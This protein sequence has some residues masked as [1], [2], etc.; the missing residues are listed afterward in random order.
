MA[1]RS[2][3]GEV[4]HKRH[5]PL[6]R[7]PLPQS[8]GGIFSRGLRPHRSPRF[9]VP[10]KRMIFSPIGAVANPWK[11]ASERSASCP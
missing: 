1:K 6:L 5:P 9:F 7:R 10:F 4:Q 11:T 2:K 3:R 8:P